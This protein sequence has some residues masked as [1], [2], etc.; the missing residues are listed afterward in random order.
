MTCL[1]PFDFD[2]LATDEQQIRVVGN[3]PYNIS[4]PLIF[5]L[6]ENISSIKDMHFMLQKEV[7]D[8]MASRPGD[9]AYGRLGIMTQ[10]YCKV[11][12]LFLCH[13]SQIPCG[14]YSQEDS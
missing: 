2:Q 13:L 5:H 9:S 1:K 4:T 6:L 3:L 7:V 10:Y 14:H 11:Q 8:R 12:P